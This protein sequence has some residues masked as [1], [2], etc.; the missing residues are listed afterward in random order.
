MKTK[1]RL[2]KLRSECWDW[3]QIIENL[4]LVGMPRRDAELGILALVDAGLCRIEPQPGEPTAFVLT[5]PDGIRE[6]ILSNVAL[7]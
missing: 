3:D 1:E 4:R 7:A 2:R 5:M 6:E